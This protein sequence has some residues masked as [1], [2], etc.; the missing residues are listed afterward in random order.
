MLHH[1]KTENGTNTI[2]PKCGYQMPFK[3]T[4]IMNNTT[5]CCPS[6]DTQYF[7]ETPEIDWDK[8]KASINK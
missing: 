8:I 3:A 6:C 1:V 7:V 4:V 2:C 5:R